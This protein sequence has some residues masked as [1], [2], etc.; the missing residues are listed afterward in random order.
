[1]PGDVWVTVSLNSFLKEFGGFPSLVYIRSHDSIV[2]NRIIS[3]L[4]QETDDCLPC[5]GIVGSAG[6]GKSIVLMTVCLTLWHNHGRNLFIV[7]TMAEGSLKRFAIVMLKGE[8][9]PKTTRV[10]VFDHWCEVCGAQMW[11]DKSCE[12]TVLIVVDGWDKGRDVIMDDDLRRMCDL[13]SS[14]NFVDDVGTMGDD[15]FLVSAWRFSDLQDLASKL[16]VTCLPERQYAFC[17]GSLSAFLADP[18]Q[19]R[20][21]VCA[22]ADNLLTDSDVDGTPQLISGTACTSLANP[23]Y[24]VYDVSTAAPRAC[25]DRSRWRLVLDVGYVLPRYIHN[26]SLS[27]YAASLAWT[28]RLN[29]EI[30]KTEFCSLKLNDGARWALP[31]LLGYMHRLAYESRMVI[32]VASYCSPMVRRGGY[33]GTR[34]TSPSTGDKRAWV[35]SGAGRVSCLQQLSQPYRSGEISYWLPEEWE[36][37]PIDA[38]LYCE[39]MGCALMLKATVTAEVVIDAGE[40]KAAH[41]ALLSSLPSDWIVQ[42]VLVMPSVVAHSFAPEWVSQVPAQ[43]AKQSGVHTVAAIIKDS[44]CTAKIDDIERILWN[45]RGTSWDGRFYEQLGSPDTDSLC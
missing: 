11:F 28:L 4:A 21:T 19:L 22:Q 43:V 18:A 8:G 12:R 2:I 45:D 41:D 31:A 16:S 35:R 40:L 3:K 14:N 24:R 10:G 1:M 36:D 30:D 34:Y 38:V 37:S 5:T 32:E 27:A 13:Y 25:G 6:V 42:L 23:L 39:K 20:I 17:G 26:I 33:H 7:R 29:S 9:T 44:S 15:L